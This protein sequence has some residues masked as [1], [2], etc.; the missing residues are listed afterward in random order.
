MYTTDF[1]QVQ[2]PLM[3]RVALVLALALSGTGAGLK[4]ATTPRPP[5]TPA[6]PGRP[7][8]TPSCPNQRLTVDVVFVDGGDIV[9]VDSIMGTRRQITRTGRSE[10]NARSARILTLFEDTLRTPRNGKAA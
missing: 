8:G 6:R 5:G 3:K 4:A 2:V 10:S 7:P 1:P 9:L